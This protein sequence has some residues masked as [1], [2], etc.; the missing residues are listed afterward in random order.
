MA[1]GFRP[2]GGH[3]GDR[4]LDQEVRH[5][6]VELMEREAWLRERKHGIGG[7]DAAAILGQNPWRSAFALYH[8]KISE[9]VDDR[10][11][12]QTRW[13]NRLEPIVREAYA[14]EVER[15][16]DDGVVL[17][18]HPEH[19]WMLANTDGTIRPVPE[20]VGP[21]VYEGKT[22]SVF[23]GRDWAEGV[24]LYHQIQLHH[25]MGVTGYQWGSAAC[26]ILGDRGDPLVW[27]DVERVD[28]FVDHLIE[29]EYDFWHKHVLAR[30]PPPVDGSKTTAKLLKELHP[31]DNGNVIILGPDLALHAREDKRLRGIIREA[32]N[33]RAHHTNTLKAAMGA[34]SYARVVDGGGDLVTRLSY[35]HQF[36]PPSGKAVLKVV[37][38]TLGP[39]TADA[40]R[41][42]VNTDRGEQRVL[43]ESSEKTV[44]EAEE[45]YG[46]ASSEG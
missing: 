3:R 9:E 21:G 4:Y 17:M 38:E 39:E 1:R 19:P 8:D 6:L 44:K 12:P 29:V 16:V 10:G 35:K 27:R 24:P 28:R 32:A 43:R 23:N 5:G 11:T 7:S 18:Q 14:E 15:T 31:R 46:E 41:E 37:E 36:T 22:T 2:I 40:V 30:V 26:L 33:E 25:Y 20:H 45:R 42:A 34:A 13:G